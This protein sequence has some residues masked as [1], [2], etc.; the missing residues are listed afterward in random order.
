MESLASLKGIAMLRVDV[1]PYLLNHTALQH[2]FI[3]ALVVAP[4]WAFLVKPMLHR[5]PHQGRRFYLFW[6]G[7]LS[8]VLQFL[9]TVVPLRLPSFTRR[10]SQPAEPRGRPNRQSSKKELGSSEEEGKRY[11]TG[12]PAVTKVALDDLFRSPGFRE[13]YGEHRQSLLE[14]VRLRSSQHLWA[15]IATLIVTLLGFFVLPLFTFSNN[16]KT[17]YAI[18]RPLFDVPPLNIAALTRGNSKSEALY[19]AAL[20][21]RKL[22]EALLLLVAT[23]TLFTTA[24]MPTGLK[25]TALFASAAFAVLVVE[26]AR[27]ERMA[28]GAG[29]ACLLFPVAWRIVSVLS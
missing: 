19:L 3:V 5:H 18:L 14:R 9:S 29:F 24:F 15:S 26:A 6:W 4:L 2:A 7:Q 22:G 10:P 8:S 16:G 1:P 20:Y 13:W 27:L 12:G 28:A 11:A 25:Q 21:L 17:M 23:C